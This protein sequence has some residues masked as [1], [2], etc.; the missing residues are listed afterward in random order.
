MLSKITL[1]CYFFKYKFKQDIRGETY[2]VA[3][4]DKMHSSETKKQLI[5]CAKAEFTEKGFAGAS[6]RSIC[7]RAGVTTG[8]LYF[9]FKDKD[10][11]FCEVVGALL[12]H[13]N[14]MIKEHHAFELKESQPAVGDFH[15]TTSDYEAMR[16]I[17]HELYQNREETLLLLT[18]AQGS[19][20]E[21]VTDRIVDMM[22]EHNAILC[23]AMC[24]A[25]GVPMV[26]KKVVHWM[27]HSQIDMFIFMVTH[28]D[29]EKEAMD[30]AEK[31]MK[32]LLAG[33]Y[34]IVKS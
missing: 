11:L 29:N 14:V 28:I 23:E 16:L 31:G 22:D 3:A 18:G 32:Y 10:E 15:D 2:T 27:S 1:L 7:K 34:A 12:E 30:F 8:A 24:R 17:V 33:W 21:H 19:T 5:R 6:L 9:F 4:S 25:N 20:M 13:L 26:D